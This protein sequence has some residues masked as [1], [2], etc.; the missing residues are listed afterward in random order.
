MIKKQKETN[1]RAAA[2]IERQRQNH[3]LEIPEVRQRGYPGLNI[4]KIY[5]LKMNLLKKI[6]L[7][8]PRIKVIRPPKRKVGRWEYIS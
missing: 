3:I 6:F 4:S 5:L 7:K 8:T 2:T 1:Q